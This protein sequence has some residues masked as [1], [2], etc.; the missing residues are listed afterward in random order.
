MCARGDFVISFKALL[1]LNHLMLWRLTV[2]APRRTRPE[3][4][5]MSSLAASPSFII[6]VNFLSK[7]TEVKITETNNKIIENNY[8]HQRAQQSAC[9]NRIMNSEANGRKSELNAQIK[10]LGLMCQSRP[11]K[12]E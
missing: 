11:A 5:M 12:L 2:C 6:I 1:P 3:S 9:M 4:S 10:G 7:N 8:V